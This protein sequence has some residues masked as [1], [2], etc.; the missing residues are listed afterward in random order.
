MWTYSGLFIEKTDDRLSVY[1]SDPEEFPLF[2]DKSGKLHKDIEKMV[3]PQMKINGLYQCII[4]YCSM[5]NPIV[6]SC[7]RIAS[8]NWE[9]KEDKTINI[10]DEIDMEIIHKE[11]E[12]VFK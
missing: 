11:I 1:I 7:R 9:H 5:S 2:V 12:K 4:G 6:Y 8:V 10:K 3:N